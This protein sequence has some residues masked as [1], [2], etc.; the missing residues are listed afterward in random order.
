MFIRCGVGG[1]SSLLP[2]S[3]SPEPLDRISV[4]ED[5]ELSEV[6]ASGSFL[7]LSEQF[8]SG[9]VDGTM[10]FSCIVAFR[11]VQFTL[12]FFPLS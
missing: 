12:H 8:L 2:I 5:A 11:I 4:G 6:V 3:S 1:S 7:M 10:V 9:D